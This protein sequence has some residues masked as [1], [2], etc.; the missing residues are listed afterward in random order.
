MQSGTIPAELFRLVSNTL[1][2]IH[3]VRVCS[4]YVLEE[5]YSN[6]QEN[7]PNNGKTQIFI[8][9]F[10]AC[11]ARLKLYTY[12]QK[13]GQ[14][15]GQMTDSVI[16]SHKSCEPNIPLG[17][18]LGEMTNELENG[19]HI[20]DFMSAG[21]KNCGYKTANGKVCCKVRGFT[22]NVRGFRQL[23]YKGTRQNLLTR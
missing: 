7:Q 1:L 16:F 4:E 3:A 11:Y 5:G 9:S 23:N 14:Q 6:L 2:N 19:D 10:T 21:P 22:L 18:Y 8:A 12:L 13:L 15:V 20:V 17:H